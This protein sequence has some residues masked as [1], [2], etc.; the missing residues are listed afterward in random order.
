MIGT[1]PARWRWYEE[2][3]LLRIDGLARTRL[4]PVTGHYVAF[5]A[6]RP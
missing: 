5:L 1:R 6:E 2:R 3:A 4:A